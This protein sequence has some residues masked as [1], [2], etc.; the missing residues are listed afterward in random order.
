MTASAHRDRPDSWSLPAPSTC[1]PAYV[2][3]CDDAVDLLPQ[4]RGRDAS[5]EDV[6]GRDPSLPPAPAVGSV[7]PPSGRMLH[8]SFGLA[9][10]SPDQARH[11]TGLSAS[12]V[13]APVQ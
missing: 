9:L 2:S 6:P 11:P 4:R 7:R 3:P 1:G 12:L 5:R 13:L 8:P 10:R